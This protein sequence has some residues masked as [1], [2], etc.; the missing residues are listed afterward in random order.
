M[1]SYR[2]VILFTLLASTS[3]HARVEAQTPR[4]RV[5]AQTPRDEAALSTLIV[6][7]RQIASEVIRPD[8]Q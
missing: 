7:G 1:R 6:V 3:W 5:E 4:G 8:R 2:L